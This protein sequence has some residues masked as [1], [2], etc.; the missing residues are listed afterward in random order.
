MELA[1]ILFLFVFV[2]FGLFMIWTLNRPSERQLG[3]QAGFR[4]TPSKDNE[5][6]GKEKRSA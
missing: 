6:K 1:A 3:E 4:Q 5:T 2:A